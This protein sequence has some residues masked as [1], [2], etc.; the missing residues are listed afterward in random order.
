[1][2]LP[3]RDPADVA[4]MRRFISAVMRREPLPA[5]PP[6]VR[7]LQTGHLGPTAFR[8]GLSERRDE[9]AASMV[10]ADR[11]A[12]TLR[13]VA[14]HFATCGIEICLIKGSAFAGTI[15]PDPA[16]RPMH[17]IDVLVRIERLDEA[18]EL[19]LGIGFRRVGFTRKLSDY[20]HAVVF[21]RGDIMFELHRSI[22]QRHRTQLPITSLWERSIPDPLGSG[23]RRLDRVDDLIICALH[24][25][26]HELAVPAINFVDVSRLWDRL[27]ARER[28][29]FHERAAAYRITRSMRAVLSMTEHLADG[30]TGAPDVGPGSEILPSTDD[31]ILGTKPQRGRQIAQKLLLTEGAR[32][33]LGLGFAWVA[34]IVEGWWR[35][36]T[37]DQR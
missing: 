24:V 7:L 13:E 20:Y 25:A 12:R 26:R 35:G 27:D 36:R 5:D 15:Y 28:E 30:A 37:F 18:I 10:M 8:M 2:A 22:V 34:A 17:D 16:E 6:S 1:L 31:V 23:A 32:E 9:Y 11:R 19:I 29:V 14:A 21:C 33:R 3:D 4:R